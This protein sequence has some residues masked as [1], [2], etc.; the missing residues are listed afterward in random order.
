MKMRFVACMLVLALLLCGVAAYAKTTTT[1]N[2]YTINFT[3]DKHLASSSSMYGVYCEADATLS[4]AKSGWYVRAALVGPLGNTL[5]DSGRQYTSRVSSY[6]YAVTA[7]VNK[8][9][10]D[11]HARGY[12]GG[13]Y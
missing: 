1:P 11:V 5:V 4:P 6:N 10:S 8:H 2:G 7:S 13:I 9:Y 12:W 3:Y